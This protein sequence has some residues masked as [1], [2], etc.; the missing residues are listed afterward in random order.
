MK[1]FSFAQ[2]F[3]IIALNA[4]NSLHLTTAKI[5]SLRCMAAAVMLEKYLDKG[6]TK[7]GE[8]LT[9]TTEDL[10]SAAI[11]TYQ[12]SVVKVIL[13]KKETMSLTLPEYLRKVTKLSGKMLKEVEH[14]FAISLKEENAIEEIPALLGCDLEY[15]TAGI[16]MREYRSQTDLYRRIAESLRAESL[17]E[18]NMTDEAILMLWLLRESGCLYDL[19]SKIELKRVA[20]RMIEMLD[21]SALAKQIYPVIIHKSIETAVKNFLNMKK[22]VMSTPTGSGINFI[23]PLIERSQSVFIDTEEYFANKEDRLRD[24]IARLESQGHHY[25]VIRTGEV[26]LIKIDNVLYE[27]VPS[28][29]QYPVP[30]HGVRLRKHPLS[31]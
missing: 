26:P 19:F 5:V 23:F 27:A 1:E 28:A 8:V 13:G 4:Q 21:S 6:F 25:S 20:E 15:V 7:A 10:Q 2:N 14:G 18:G 30:V 9:I 11:P 29:K 12:E 3:S 31:L 22:E 16:S 24:V 17:E